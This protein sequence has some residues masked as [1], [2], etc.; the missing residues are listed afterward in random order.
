MRY[1]PFFVFFPAII[2]YTIRKGPTFHNILLFANIIKLGSIGFLCSFFLLRNDYYV[3]HPLFF[4]SRLVFFF[5]Q[6][7]SIINF[8]SFYAVR[9]Y[10]FFSF[11][12]RRR[13]SSYYS[14]RFDLIILRS[15][16]SL[17]LS[18]KPLTTNREFF[19]YLSSFF[20]LCVSVAA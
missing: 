8:E 3:H 1:F 20:V 2:Y 12:F 18:T 16:F 6:F 5:T 19:I 11:S 7:N 4:A 17:Y 15:L 14:L 10:S 13:F 9:F